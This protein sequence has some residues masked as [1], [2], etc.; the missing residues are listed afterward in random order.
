MSHNI[1]KKSGG[2]FMYGDTLKFQ[3]TDQLVRK[4]RSDEA[5]FGDL[6]AKV[7]PLLAAT[8]EAVADDDDAP[9][10]FDGDS[11]D[12]EAILNVGTDLG[13]ADE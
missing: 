6:M 4:V 8:K 13:D 7:R 11:I 10:D 12:L 5:L 2:W 9:P 1:V 3:G